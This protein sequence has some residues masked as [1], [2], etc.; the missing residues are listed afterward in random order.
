[1]TFGS[2]P[3]QADQRP[4]PRV[5]RAG[6]GVG[7]QQVAIVQVGHRLDQRKSQPGTRRGA[8]LVGAEKAFSGMAAILH[9]EAGAVIGHHD[10]DRARRRLRRLRRDLVAQDLPRPDETLAALAAAAGGR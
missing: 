10:L 3:W 5:A 9:G 2:W 6:L 4:H 7:Q 1:M 8:G